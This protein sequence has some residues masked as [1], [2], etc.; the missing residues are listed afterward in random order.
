MMGLVYGYGCSNRLVAACDLWYW[1]ASN[2]N[3]ITDNYKWTS[4]RPPRGLDE[5][6]YIDR[7]T[8]ELNTPLDFYCPADAFEYGAI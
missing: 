3:K 4:H 1:D 8:L 2:S 6:G 5:G 7:S